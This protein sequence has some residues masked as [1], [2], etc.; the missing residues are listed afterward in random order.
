M[1]DR[2]TEGSPA[3]NPQPAQRAQALIAG[4]LKRHRRMVAAF[5]LAQR[6]AAVADTGGPDA[7]ADAFAPARLGDYPVYAV[8]FAN[9]AGGLCAALLPEPVDDEALFGFTCEPLGEGLGLAPREAA[10]LMVKILLQT[11]HNTDDSELDDAQIRTLSKDELRWILIAETARRDGEIVLEAFE[12]G[13]ESIDP[14]D[15]DL[16]PLAALLDLPAHPAPDDP[17]AA[18]PSGRD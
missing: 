10:E 7:A 6:S 3:G 9:H 13:E 14:P 4:F 2:A 11:P 8:H 12:R 15:R 17:Q 1:T 16:E 5:A 18:P